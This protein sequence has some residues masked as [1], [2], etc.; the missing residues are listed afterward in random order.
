LADFAS[1]GFHASRNRTGAKLIDLKKHRPKHIV[2][3][4]RLKLVERE[5]AAG[6]PPRRILGLVL[7]D[8]F[9]QAL[10]RRGRDLALELSAKLLIRLTC[11]M[12]MSYTRH[13]PLTSYRR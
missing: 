5:T 7:L 4:G 10:H 11:S 2:S 1:E 8:L 12:T 3:L 13:W 9:A 6:L